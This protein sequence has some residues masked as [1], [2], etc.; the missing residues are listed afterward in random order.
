[1]NLILGLVIPGM[2]KYHKHF[3]C[4]NFHKDNIPEQ[5]YLQYIL[6]IGIHF[7]AKFDYDYFSY[8]LNVS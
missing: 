7:T 4:P 6:S 8:I 2:G 1:M 5:K 3:L